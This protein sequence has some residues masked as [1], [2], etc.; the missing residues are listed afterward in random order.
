[1]P[2]LIISSLAQEVRTAL[3]AERI[4]MSHEIDFFGTKQVRYQLD[5]LTTDDQVVCDNGFLEG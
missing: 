3:R 2:G 4:G 5:N 1:M